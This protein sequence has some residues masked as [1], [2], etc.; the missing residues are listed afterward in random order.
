M[1]RHLRALRPQHPPDFFGGNMTEEQACEAY[2]KAR[3]LLDEVIASG[4]H[5]N[6]EEVWLELE[7]DL[8]G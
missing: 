2:W 5:G 8:R 3:D 1:D 6:K 4:Y 7:D